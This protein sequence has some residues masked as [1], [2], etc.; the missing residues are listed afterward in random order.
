MEAEEIGRAALG[1]ICCPEHCGS[2]PW[3]VVTRRNVGW[4]SSLGFSAGSV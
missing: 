2:S 1:S 4:I 3:R